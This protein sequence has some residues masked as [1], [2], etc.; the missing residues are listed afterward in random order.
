M[1]QPSDPQLEKRVEALETQVSA[2]TTRTS[3]LETQVSALTSR[4]SALEAQMVSANSEITGLD[5]RV[6]ALEVGTPPE[7]EPGLEPVLQQN[8][9]AGSWASTWNASNQ[10]TNME[11]SNAYQHVGGRHL[12]CSV[13]MH[14]RAPGDN[15]GVRWAEFSASGAPTGGY[16]WPNDDL[17]IAETDNFPTAY[18]PSLGWI[19]HGC[20]ADVNINNSRGGIKIIDI[21]GTPAPIFRSKDGGT[22]N[23]WTDFHELQIGTGVTPQMYQSNYNPACLVNPPSGSE[24]CYFGGGVFNS[25]PNGNPPIMVLLKPNPAYPAT[26]TKPLIFKTWKYGG[27]NALCPTHMRHAVLIG[28]WIYWGGCVVAVNGQG[29]GSRTGEFYRI[30]WS[31]IKAG[32]TDFVQEQITSCQ[33][34]T[35]HPDISNDMMFRARFALLAADT[36]RR[37]LIYINIDGVYRYSVPE[38]DGNNGVWE[39]PF[40]FGISDWATTISEGFLQQFR[41]WHGC[42]GT[43]NSALNQTFFRYNLSKQW[44]RITWPEAATAPELP[45]DMTAQWFKTSEV[46]GGDTLVA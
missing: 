43:H 26:S 10:R 33:P 27:T 14:A 45:A 37:K 30:K 16:Y 29:V 31:D 42:I 40:T 4:T 38:D 32:V 20:A 18:L 7:P 5:A 35:S 22:T 46:M 39:G 28:D 25:Y 23:F 41:V 24:T 15:T 9:N 19:W 12:E 6:D 44:H 1:P 8:L 2:L 34:V 36:V 3:T 21:D 17:N 11:Y 13:A